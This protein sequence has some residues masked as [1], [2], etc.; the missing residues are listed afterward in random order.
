MAFTFT[1]EIIGILRL[2]TKMTVIA[3][4]DYFIHTPPFHMSL[5]LVTRQTKTFQIVSTDM[6][7]TLRNSLLEFG[8]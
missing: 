1:V 3:L 7:G 6:D 8:S 5:I 4:I 2:L